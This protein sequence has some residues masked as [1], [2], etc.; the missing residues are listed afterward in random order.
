MGISDGD[1]VEVSA[2]YTPYPATITDFIHP[3]AVFTFRSCKDRLDQRLKPACITMCT[4]QAL[5]PT[6]LEEVDLYS[7][8]P[9][10]FTSSATKICLTQANHYTLKVQP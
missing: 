9:Y 10:F 4:T 2:E 6:K 1:L 5:K 7:I 3:E 8:S